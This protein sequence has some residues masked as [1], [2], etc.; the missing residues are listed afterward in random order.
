MNKSIIPLV[1]ALFGP[2]QGLGMSQHQPLSRFGRSPAASM[3]LDPVTEN[4]IS[5]VMRDFP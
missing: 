5:R 2:N 4:E 3:V 1:L